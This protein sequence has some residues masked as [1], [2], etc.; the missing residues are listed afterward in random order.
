MLNAL[1]PSDLWTHGMSPSTAASLFEGLQ[2][3]SA[4]A[5]L[6]APPATS[7]VSSPMAPPDPS[8]CPQGHSNGAHALTTP[9]SLQ[10]GKRCRSPGAQRPGASKRRAG[11][12]GDAVGG[13]ACHFAPTGLD[14][15][16]DASD[17]DKTRTSQGE[18]AG[19]DEHGQDE[20]ADR[21]RASSDT[22]GRGGGGGGDGTDGADN[23]TPSGDSHRSSPVE[24]SPDA[25][26]DE[27]ED[28]ED[29]VDDDDEGEDDDDDDD[30]DDDESPFKFLQN[31]DPS[32]FATNLDALIPPAQPL[33]ESTAHP[34]ARREGHAAPSAAATDQEF[35][36]NMIQVLTHLL[37]SSDHG[38]WQ[39]GAHTPASIMGTSPAAFA[40]SSPAT[41]ATPSIT[42]NRN[43]LLVPSSNKGLTGPARGHR[44]G[45]QAA[46][47]P[48]LQSLMSQQQRLQEAQ[49]QSGQVGAQDQTRD[50]LHNGSNLQRTVDP[51]S[52][53]LQAQEGQRHRQAGHSAQ[54]HPDQEEQQGQQEQQQQHH[55]QAP[56]HSSGSGTAAS[57]SV[58]GSGGYP[59][60]QASTGPALGFA[61]LVFEEEDEDDPD[62]NPDLN[63][64][65]PMPSA[66]SL[67][68]QDVVSSKSSKAAALAA[69]ASA[70]PS[71]A[72]AEH[73]PAQEVT[74][75]ADAQRQ[76]TIARATE[77]QRP[78]Q[79]TSASIPEKQPTR[80][81]AT[82]P[83]GNVRTDIEGQREPQH[84]TSHTASRGLAMPRDDQVRAQVLSGSRLEVE[85]DSPMQMSIQ[86][87]AGAHRHSE[88]ATSATQPAAV[89]ATPSRDGAPESGHDATE[90]ASPS[91]EIKRGRKRLF[92]DEERR[93]RKLERQAEYARARRAR[94][95]EERKAEQGSATPGA[96]S[97]RA[98]SGRMSTQE[99]L[100]LRAEVSML[101]SEMEKLREENARLRAC[102]ERIELERHQPRSGP[103]RHIY[104]EDQARLSHRHDGLARGQRIGRHRDA[105]FDREGVPP[106]GYAGASRASKLRPP[107][108]LTALDSVPFDGPDDASF[109]DSMSDYED[110]DDEGD[111]VWSGYDAAPAASLRARASERGRRRDGFDGAASTQRRYVRVFDEG[112]DGVAASAHSLYLSRDDAV[113]AEARRQRAMMTASG[114]DARPGP[115][116]VAQHFG[117]HDAS[118]D[119]SLDSAGSAV[120]AG[121]SGA[122]S[123]GRSSGARR[124]PRMSIDDYDGGGHRA[125][126]RH[127][128]A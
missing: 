71:P 45:G 111:D 13:G 70:R 50:G 85:A 42:A 100:E 22:S 93:L 8:P 3:R 61:D 116:R 51:E 55:V 68:V 117:R 6:R 78:L 72:G 53:Q 75:N 99:A 34:D 38:L 73:T 17:S 18:G 36:S 124:R 26:D 122:R 28:E 59:G 120:A 64:D 115:H 97:G 52:L 123:A 110:D 33:T 96:S 20:P 82:A 92:T 66:W 127:Y 11:Q 60:G 109:A 95:R 118:A 90:E 24:D 102:Q 44:S 89:A 25:D 54:I 5:G 79:A 41:H 62:F 126:T 4:L 67:A 15:P 114:V 9:A 57:L 7:A 65:L 1:S 84:N 43:S 47:V 106:G 2:A 86:E 128:R 105:S 27:D 49:M 125:A 101:R 83:S 112:V 77:R 63:P 87:L 121:L 69:A 12:S 19:Q 32:L 29:D 76:R 119:T 16:H 108:G 56:T 104:R 39:A 46:G 81:L 107:D 30:D 80:A 98:A 48:D 10:R 37:G 40:Q 21:S 23:E 35:Y 58:P 74:A 91:A 94:L 14:A 88:P 103:S 31:F 113:G